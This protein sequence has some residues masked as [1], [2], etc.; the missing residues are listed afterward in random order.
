LRQKVKS[1]IFAAGVRAL[2]FQG[3]GKGKGKGEGKVKGKEGG[4]GE[5]RKG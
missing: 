5:G 1:G 3:K 4:W 2:L